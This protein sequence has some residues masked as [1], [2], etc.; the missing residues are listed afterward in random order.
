M[1]FFATTGLFIVGSQNAAEERFTEGR[2]TFGRLCRT[3]RRIAYELIGKLELVGVGYR[4][5]PRCQTNRSFAISVLPSWN[6]EDVRR[7][8]LRREAREQT[9]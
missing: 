2:A 8:L 1:P 7:W 4:E 5:T 9:R 6:T 3:M